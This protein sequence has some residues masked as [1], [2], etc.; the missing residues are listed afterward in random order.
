MTL[1]CLKSHQNRLI[2]YPDAGFF[3]A[4]AIFPKQDIL[5]DVSIIIVNYHSSQLVNDCIASVFKL[6]EGVEYE[7]IVIDNNSENLSQSIAEASDPRVKL[8]QLPE[9]VGFGRAN[10]EGF[11]I[12]RGR[13]LFCLNPDT[14][15]LNNAVKILSDYLDGH[16]DCG[17]CGGNLYDAEMH[18]SLSF[19]RMLPGIVWELNELSHL[20]IDKVCH[21]KNRR[22]NFT[23][24]PI[25]VAYI[26]G[27][28]LMMPASIVKATGGFSPE[29]FMYYEETDLCCRIRRMD[30]K[31]ISVPEAKIQ[32]LEGATFDASTV[33]YNRIDRSEKGRRTYYRR[34]H[35]AAYRHVADAIYRL[36]LLSRKALTDN[37]AYSYRLK[38][39]RELQ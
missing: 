21:G 23:G 32:H 28:D 39:L 6:T 8:I 1:L 10:N 24:H 14:I 2:L 31:I 16:S 38:K 37:P 5:M 27:A 18:P 17:A 35:G 20:I 26:T 15:L 29:F 25:E 4:F 13:N 22:F 11:R 3:L 19:K 9:N 7:V 30:R 12:A 33:N 34:N 36:F